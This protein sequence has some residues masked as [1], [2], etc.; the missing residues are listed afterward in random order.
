MNIHGTQKN[1]KKR[2][3]YHYVYIVTHNFKR[4]KKLGKL[5][6]KSLQFK[7]KSIN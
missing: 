7:F 3:K 2:E 1:Y 6:Q 5:L 4:H